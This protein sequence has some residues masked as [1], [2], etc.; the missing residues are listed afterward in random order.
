MAMIRYCKH[1]DNWKDEKSDFYLGKKYP[2]TR[3]KE[4]ERKRV[5]IHAKLSYNNPLKRL[6]IKQNRKNRESNPEIKDHIRKRDRDKYHKDDRKKN[7]IRKYFQKNKTKIYAN[8][9]KRI[10]ENPILRLRK[11]I[12][13]S[14]NAAL[15]IIGSSKR[16]E[17]ILKYL[18]Y[19]INNL[20]K[21]LESQFEPWMNWGNFGAY[22]KNRK[23]WQIDHIIPQVS[24]PYNSMAHLNF[25]KCWSINNLRP[26][27]AMENMK[28]GA[29]Y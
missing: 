16:G 15:K 28:K 8:R 11:L 23:T 13:R 24:L 14:V 20:K 7:A 1:C 29:K 19:T 12:S 18:P 17:S 5:R 25:Q 10:R 6:I 3:C 9:D 26:L 4:C 27:E 22:D 2:S 21:H